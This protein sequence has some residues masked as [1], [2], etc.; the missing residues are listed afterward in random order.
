MRRL[1][2]T[3]AMWRMVRDKRGHLRRGG[4]LKVPPILTVDEWEHLAAQQQD[5]LLA[6]CR[7]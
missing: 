1:R 2:V 4:V 5:K 7:L 6:E 3:Q